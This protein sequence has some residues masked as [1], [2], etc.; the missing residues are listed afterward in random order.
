ME[1][2]RGL[3]NHFSFGWIAVWITEIL[4]FVEKPLCKKGVDKTSLPPRMEN[5]ANS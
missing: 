5:V 2:L 1:N 3:E 4:L